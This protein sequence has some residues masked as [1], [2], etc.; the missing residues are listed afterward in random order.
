MEPWC[1][2][3]LLLARR[4]CAAH[5]WRRPHAQLLLAFHSS[6]LCGCC[7]LNRL[8]G[9]LSLVGVTSLF[10]FPSAFLVFAGS[11]FFLSARFL[12]F[13]LRAVGNCVAARC[14]DGI[15]RIDPTS[16]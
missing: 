13:D 11:F 16:D 12:D 7:F 1:A 14:D 6:F 4:H 3:I 8:V 2:W 15:S 5:N 9:L 10:A